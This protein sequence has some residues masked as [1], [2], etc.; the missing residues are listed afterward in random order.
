MTL[1]Q[2]NPTSSAN[3]LKTECQFFGKCGGCDFLNLSNQDYH[4]LKKERLEK[5]LSN[6][7]SYDF[8]SID[9]FWV[10]EKSRR[11]ITLQIDRQ[12]RIGFF[13]KKSNDLVEIDSCFIAEEK[14]SQ[15]IQPLRKF[16]KSQER[17]LFTK[18]SITLFDNVIDIVFY[19]KK[20]VSFE[21][22]QKII[23]FAQENTRENIV[24]VSSK[25][26]KDLT[27]IFLP[28]KNQVFYSSIHQDDS[29]TLKLDL[30]SEIFIQATKKGL[31]EIIRNLREYLSSKTGIKEVADIYSGYGAYSF[32]IY[33][34]VAS[35][36]AFEGNSQMADSVNKNAAQNA[37]SHKIKAFTKDLFQNSISKKE[38]KDFDL[39]IINPPRNGATPQIKEI[40][41]S[42]IENVIYISCNPQTFAF[43]AKILIDS[44]FKIKKLSALDQFHA[45]SHLELIA[46]F[47]R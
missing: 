2:S 4:N 37:L 34:L 5:T 8:K 20:E 40:S 3:E 42:N 16:I 10:G 27:P 32:A 9:Y 14:L 45:S 36:A 18:A 29:K 15:L 39:A 28:R 25:L 31:L 17:N 38:L 24:N 30:D 47:E 13:K 1:C 19:V 22:A 46:I 33:D 43:D 7:I 6:K 23:S 11:K 26:N 41:K 35:V 21:Q 12:N 44:G